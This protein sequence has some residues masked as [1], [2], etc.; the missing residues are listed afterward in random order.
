MNWEMF[1]EIFSR[2]FT[3][4][5]AAGLAMAALIGIVLAICL[6][7]GLISFIPEWID[8]RRKKK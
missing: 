4:L 1:C 6:V 8:D 5:S 2:V 7:I 3:F